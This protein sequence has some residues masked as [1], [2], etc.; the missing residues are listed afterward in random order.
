MGDVNSYAMA[1]CG[2]RLRSSLRRGREGAVHRRAYNMQTTGSGPTKPRGYTG[3]VGALAG[4]KP[5]D[6]G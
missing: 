2:G 6:I 5:Q 4:V 3:A 1:G